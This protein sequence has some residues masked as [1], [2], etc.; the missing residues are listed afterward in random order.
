MN[1]S[2]DRLI[3]PELFLLLGISV[4]FFFNI[5]ISR[6]YVLWSFFLI[7][8]NFLYLLFKKEV[9]LKINSTVLLWFIFSISALLGLVMVDRDNSGHGA[10]GEMFYILTLILMLFSYVLLI[11]SDK[12]HPYY[13]KTIVWICIFFLG[14]SVI[15]M[16]NPTLLLKINTYFLSSQQITDT[17]RY[18]NRGVLSGFT[19]NPGI[20]GF[21]LSIL[22]I[23]TFLSIHKASLKGAKIILSFLFI[24]QFYI[25]L[26]TGKRGFLV[27]VIII[28]GYLTLQFTEKK[29]LALLSF[30][31]VIAILVLLIFN[32]EVGQGLIQRTLLQDDITTG[33]LPGYELMWRQFLDNPIF[34]NG[35][36]TTNSV[37]YINNGHNIY[38]QVLREHGLFGFIPFI[39]VLIS[40]LILTNSLMINTK[41]KIVKSNMMFALGIQLLVIFWGVTGNP[42]Y[43]QYPLLLY[44]TTLAFVW[45]NYKRQKNSNKK[46]IASSIEL[47]V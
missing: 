29:L 11:S 1:K 37:L 7:A 6:Y 2:Q 12:W 31:I 5:L 30:G 27:F 10:T 46:L 28:I 47:I 19:T 4:Y 22:I 33:R 39:L 41:D 15:Q 36:Y 23:Y 13:L 9:G 16:I 43:D 25:L 14:G 3:S 32:T 38:L 45:N 35:T 34:G 21:T 17:L 18:V 24:F 26:M 20:N 44:F 42:L 8:M 40:N